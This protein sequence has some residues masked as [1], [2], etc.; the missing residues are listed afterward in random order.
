MSAAPS[1]WCLVLPCYSVHHC[2]W[3][4]T[5][6]YLESDSG[7]ITSRTWQCHIRVSRDMASTISSNISDSGHLRFWTSRFRDLDLDLEILRVSDLDPGDPDPPDPPDT[8]KAP[9]LGVNSTAHWHPQMAQIPFV[10]RQTWAIWDA[11]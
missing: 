3:L 6:M 9:L 2:A 11:Y 4:R 10:R 8:P 5:T 1:V 7:H